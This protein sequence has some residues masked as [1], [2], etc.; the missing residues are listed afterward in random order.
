MQRQRGGGTY[1]A[2]RRIAY[3]ALR[4]A[5]L[6]KAEV[7]GHIGRA[8]EYFMGNLGVDLDTPVRAVRNRR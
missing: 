8:D 3:K 5:G 6:P 4:R 7:R 1:G 2:E